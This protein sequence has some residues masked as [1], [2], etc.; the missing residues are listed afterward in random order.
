MKKNYLL[1]LSSF[2]PSSGK[3]SL[4]SIGQAFQ[5]GINT[6]SFR[7]HF[8]VYHHVFR[9]NDAVTFLIQSGYAT[10]REQAVTIGRRLSEQMQLFEHVSQ[11]HRF[12]DKPL[13]YVFTRH[14]RNEYVVQTHT[15]WG[16]HL[17]RILGFL[18]SNCHASKTKLQLE[19]PFTDGFDHPRM[20]VKESLWIPYKSA[21]KVLVD[22]DANNEQAAES[23]EES[24]SEGFEQGIATFLDQNSSMDDMLEYETDNT[25]DSN[26]CVQYLKKPPNQ[27]MNMKN[28]NE[29]PIHVLLNEARNKMHG[30]LLHT[31]DDRTYQLPRESRPMTRR[32][33]SSPSKINLRPASQRH[34][35]I[36]N[37]TNSTP[38]QQQEQCETNIK[39]E[40]DKILGIG[41]YSHPNVVIARLGLF[42]QPIVE[43][44]IGWLSLFR[45]LFNI[46][47]WQDPILSFWISFLGPFLI[48]VLHLVPWR[49]VL[50][51]LGVVTLGPQNWLRRILRERKN[52]PDVFDPDRVVHPKISPI[53]DDNPHQGVTLFSSY[54]ADY[55][56]VQH[57]EES[58]RELFLSDTIRQVVVPYS[59]LLYSHRFYDWP[60]ESE[61]TRVSASCA[62]TRAGEAS[63]SDHHSFIEPNSGWE[64]D[65]DHDDVNDEASKS[66]QV[67]HRRRLR[68]QIR[69]FHPSPDHDDFDR[70][71]PRWKE[72]LHQWKDKLRHRHHGKGT[73][74]GNVVPP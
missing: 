4:G 59:P 65:F 72:S 57:S 69:Q 12:E 34:D 45:A 9:G 39:N 5:D 37:I 11:E 2:S 19:M 13:F 40:Y 6:Q 8:R 50:G 22:D 17:F 29:K 36:S 35:G 25:N 23:D 49:L 43:I 68:H 14:D 28:K 16:K 66:S 20:K 63:D 26:S 47:T 48:V 21:K 67:I 74:V 41:K 10:T 7:Y 53:V 73:T 54:L 38:Q 27:N 62:T 70:P 30:V 24:T 51:I 61:Y 60:P 42:I 44:A 31:F 18:P 71:S 52:G 64:V 33:A 1:L 15:P 58:E 3:N 56:R 46:F 32:K 55:G